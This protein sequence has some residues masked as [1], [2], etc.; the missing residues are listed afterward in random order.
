MRVLLDTNIVIHRENHRIS[1]YSIGHLFN[2][3]DKLNCEKIIHPYT[4]DELKKFG[5]SSKTELLG[6]KL[7]AYNVLKTVKVPDEEFLSII[8]G[9]GNTP[10]DRIDNSLLYEVF[11]GRVDVL[12][13]EDKG[14]KRKANLLGIENKVASIDEFLYVVTNAH[15]E[16]VDYKFL[17][18]KKELFG[19]LDID[20]DFFQSLKENYDGF[21]NWFYKKCDEPVYV[22][23]DDEDILGLLY[24]K[25]E[26]EHENYSDI[27]PIFKPAKRLKVG[28]FKV[29]ST[30]FRLGERFIKIIFDNARKA[31]VDEI[32]LTMFEGEQQ[33]MTLK[34]LLQDWG[35][36]E[37]GYKYLNGKQELILT[38][39][40][41]TYD[42]SLSVK[43]NYPYVSRDS[44]KFFL[45]IRSKYHTSIFP[46]SQLTTESKEDFTA[47][48][49]HRY[50]LEKVYVSF[51]Y[52]RNIKPGDLIMFYRMGE[53]GTNK[54][55]K[56][57]VTTVGVVEEVSYGFKTEEEFLSKCKNRTVFSRSELDKAWKTRRRELLV[58]KFI[59]LESLKS[60]PTLDYLW[61]NGIIEL[62][63]GPRPFTR[64]TDSDFDRILGDSQTELSFIEE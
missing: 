10:N 4:L 36:K 2:W 35:F 60:R 59:Y 54:R 53:P 52:E 17:S 49:P 25:V 42:R 15:P 12:I 50:A 24:L 1:N 29:E 21:E 47:K 14:I 31:K 19:D 8:G 7:Q 63:N 34:N 45:P 11:L 56:S 13:T 37:Y 39:K 20:N 55:Y 23:R 33:I 3:L 38:K 18:V 43:E 51:S 5:D 48:L 32:Y 28:T 57:V 26:D 22:C 62:P 44:Q 61:R 58:V 41:D 40:M 16:L 46:D 30:G 6:I 64:I 27:S 9:G